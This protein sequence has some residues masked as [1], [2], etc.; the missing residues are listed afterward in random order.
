MTTLTTTAP[1]IRL[2][3]E[4]PL[5]PPVLINAGHYGD[6]IATRVEWNY[7]STCDPTDYRCGGYQTVTAYADNCE[8]RTF[9]SD[10]PLPGWVPEPAAWDALKAAV[11]EAADE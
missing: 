5:D 8:N 6:I 7:A 4:I 3:V 1:V 10:E 2:S 11:Q 9:W